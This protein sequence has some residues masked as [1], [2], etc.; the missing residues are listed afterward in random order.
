ML[1]LP[2]MHIIL[3]ASPRPLPL[4]FA[5]CLHPSGC[6][7]SQLF[8]FFLSCP[9]GMRLWPWRDLS[10]AGRQVTKDPRHT[11]TL[12]DTGPRPVITVTPV[13]APLVR[14]IPM[15]GVKDYLYIYSIDEVGV[16]A[17]Y[18]DHRRGRVQ[19]VVRR[20][21]MPPAIY[22]SDRAGDGGQKYEYQE[23]RK[24]SSH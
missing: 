18:K 15:P 7:L 3:S 19:Y 21:V 23:C 17:A 22:M 4:F 24:S 2:L 9:Y 12:L 8:Q 6:S 16:G 13:P 5:L 10:I 14:A 11:S 20:T 1:V